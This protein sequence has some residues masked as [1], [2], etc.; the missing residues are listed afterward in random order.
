MP[1]PEGLWVALGVTDTLGVAVPLRV[2]EG[3][4]ESDGV[5]EPVVEGVCVAD[6]V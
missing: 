2:S 3:V 5:P 6:A 1:V 4:C